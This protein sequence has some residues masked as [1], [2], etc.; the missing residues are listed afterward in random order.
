[1]TATTSPATA[2]TTRMFFIDD[3]GAE[4][5]GWIVYS[6][7]ECAIGD[8]AAGLRGRLDLRKDIFARFAIPPAYELHSSPFAGGKGNPSTNQAWNRN[9]SN[10][11]PVMTL[12]LDQ[13]GSAPE[14]RVGTVYRQT[15]QRRKAYAAERAD[16]YEKL[17]GHLDTRLGAAREHGLLFMD[18]DGTDP[19]YARAHRGLKLASRNIIEDPLF[20]GSHQNQWIQMADIAAWSA[21]QYLR[22]GDNRRFAW[23]WYPSHLMASDAN[24]GPIVV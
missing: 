16:V 12:A 2:G 20:Q 24:G 9:K 22:Q 6:W 14:I 1:M 11:R 4:D 15:S 18:G 13:I 8:W 5:T 21:Y 19:S 23:N 10:R 17:V 7:V 3:S